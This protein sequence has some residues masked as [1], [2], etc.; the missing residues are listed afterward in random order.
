MLLN[1]CKNREEIM[2]K[3][4]LLYATIILCAL[5]LFACKGIDI[6]KV[7][8]LNLLKGQEEPQD[9]KAAAMMDLDPTLNQAVAA[10]FAAQ[11]GMLKSLPYAK[12]DSPSAV[13]I[14]NKLID[15]KSL[16]PGFVMIKDYVENGDGTMTL[17]LLTGY[18]DRYGRRLMNASYLVFRSSKPDRKEAAAIKKWIV[19][20]EGGM[21]K[22]D[23][24]YK[25]MLTGFQRQQ[26]LTP[27]G[28]FGDVSARALTQDLSMI[29]I[30]Q[31]ESITY[32]PEKPSSCIYIVPY[33]TVSKNP[34]K[35]GG[36]I[37][38]IREVANQ[39]LSLDKI[40]AAATPGKKFVLFVFFLDRIDPSQPIR[41]SLSESEQRW[42]DKLSSVYYAQPGSW[43]V[44]TETFC[45]DDTLADSRLFANIFL[46]GKYV[47]TC[48][49]G[50][51]IF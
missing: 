6:K 51:R 26:G 34:K 31:L 33:E 40:K 45:I 12:V 16:A 19:K 24:E 9:R 13:T 50:H 27:D 18:F 36:G 5:A 3:K 32:Y 29:H 11:M 47:Y 39:S 22:K 35:Y 48:V 43:P 10:V 41:L 4:I 20:N 2:M 25:K 42:G 38:S 49:A 14:E 30:K 8:P 7:N 28:V 21:F 17:R 23:K 46:K 44:I 1:L 37:N 15:T